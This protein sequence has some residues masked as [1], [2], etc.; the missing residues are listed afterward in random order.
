VQGNNMVKGPSQ[1]D[2]RAMPTPVD[3]GY[4]VG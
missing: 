1:F 3:H 4:Q 2:G